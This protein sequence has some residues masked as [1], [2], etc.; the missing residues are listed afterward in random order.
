M[1]F[2]VMLILSFVSLSLALNMVFVST[3]SHCT[4][5]HGHSVSTGLISA[6][7]LLTFPF[8]SSLSNVV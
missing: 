2:V 1:L 6:P 7:V 4:H 3:W 5:G 8:T